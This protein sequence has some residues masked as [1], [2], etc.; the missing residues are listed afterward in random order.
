MGKR[1]PAFECSPENCGELS[2]KC[3]TTSTYGRGCRCNSCKDAQ[4]AYAISYYQANRE[5]KLASNR[6]W[7]EENRERRREY[8]K[9]RYQEK[10]DEYR[11]RTREYSLRNREEIKEKARA[12]RASNK[13]VLADRHREWRS[14]NPE[15]DRV[16]ANRRR[17]RLKEAFVEDIDVAVVFKRDGYICQR[18]GIRCPKKAKWPER[19]FP[20]LDHI[21][22]LANGG[23]HCYANVQTLCYSCNSAKGARE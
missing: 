6:Q 16:R 13:E 8:S 20:T 12:W 4:R 15:A 5:Q 3:G 2:P 11:Q 1:T 22:A 10:G 7:Q 23:L 18:C 9:K 21:V 17:A 19:N 14:K